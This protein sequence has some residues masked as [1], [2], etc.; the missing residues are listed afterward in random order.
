MLDE[1]GSL[2]EEPSD[3]EQIDDE[4]MDQEVA[5]FRSFLDTLDPGDFDR[6]RGPGGSEQ[7]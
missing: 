2:L 4:S 3:D 6:E 5:D 1:A 7:N